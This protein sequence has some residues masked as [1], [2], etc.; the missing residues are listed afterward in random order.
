MTSTIDTL[1]SHRSIRRFSTQ[2]ISSDDLNTILQCGR[3]ASSSSFIQCVSVIRITCSEKR[4][5]LAH[6]AGDQ[7]YVATCAEFLVF[8]ADFHRH[9]Q[10]V[11]DAQLGFAEQTL[12]GAVDTALVA[13]NCLVA[14]ESMGLGGVYIGGLRNNPQPVSDLLALPQHVLPLFGLCLGYPAQSP[15]VKPRLPLS[16]M[17][18]TDSYQPLDRAVLADYDQQVSAYYAQRTKGKMSATWSAQIKEKLTKESRPFMQDF[19]NKKGFS[20]R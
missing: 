19:L 16:L 5:T 18:H 7:P 8:C 12:I 1:L 20:Q 10:I 13:Q 2:S 15:E 6:L 4:A 9:D 17:V 14:A 3:A 11:D